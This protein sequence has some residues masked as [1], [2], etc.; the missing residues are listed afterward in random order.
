M[1][2][3]QPLVNSYVKGVIM[4][5]M[6]GNEV[7]ADAV[8]NSLVAVLNEQTLAK[9]YTD[10]ATLPTVLA[11]VRKRTDSIVITIDST[12]PGGRKELAALGTKIN[13]TS[14]LIDGFG[15]SLV[16]GQKKAIKVTD[17]KRKEARDYLEVLRQEVLTPVN[18]YKAEAERLQQEALAKE[19]YLADWDAAIEH[20]NTRRLIDEANS[21]VQAAEMKVK[22]AEEVA[23]IVGAKPAAD[24]GGNPGGIIQP[25]DP[26]ID[27]KRQVNIK[28]MEFLLECGVSEGAARSVIVRVATGQTDLLKIVY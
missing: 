9:V 12:T 27:R 28:V 18:A 8:E 13:K 17:D 24:I 7:G 25:L 4:N 6:D 3:N 26:S 1:I 10:P 2:R 16:A 14:E 20:N 19:K 21:R 23:K 11:E 15:K 5:E 22:V